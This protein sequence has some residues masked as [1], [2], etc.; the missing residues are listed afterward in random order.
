M[1]KWFAFY[2]YAYGA[3]PDSKEFDTEQELL[4]FIKE[5]LAPDSP[6]WKLRVI[7]GKEVEFEPHTYVESY[8]IK[9]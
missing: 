4:A 6:F 3:K 2:T 9:E 5:A 8:R 7:Y 1:E